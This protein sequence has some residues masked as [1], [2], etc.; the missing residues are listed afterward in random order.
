[1]ILPETILPYIFSF[2]ISMRDACNFVI[3][4][5][6]K[7]N[8][9]ICHLL[10]REFLQPQTEPF[11]FYKFHRYVYMPSGKKSALDHYK[12]VDMRYK[13]KKPLVFTSSVLELIEVK[14]RREEKWQCYYELKDPTEYFHLRMNGFIYYFCQNNNFHPQQFQEYF[15]KNKLFIKTTNNS[16]MHAA[17]QSF[18]QYVKI[19]FVIYFDLVEKIFFPSALSF[20]F[21]VQ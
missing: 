21:Y 10:H 2:C 12:I 1:M 4:I 14:L 18:K 9:I 7:P 17:N 19:Q 8:G 15:K 16:P 5:N 20:Q 13:R 6:R 3:A 11:I